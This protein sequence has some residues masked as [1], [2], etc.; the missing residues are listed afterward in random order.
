MLLDSKR[1][2]IIIVGLTQWWLT[3]D[4]QGGSQSVEGICCQSCCGNTDFD[5]S[6]QVVPL[7]WSEK[8][9]C[10]L[11]TRGVTAEEL[12]FSKVVVAGSQVPEYRRPLVMRW[13]CWNLSAVLCSVM[14]EEIAFITNALFSLQL[15][16]LVRMCYRWRDGLSSQRLCRW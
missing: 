16:T 15:H 3:F 13:T 14:A 11:L 1:A 7:F 10:H 6:G 8:P 5:F 2:F 4:G 12:I 9:C